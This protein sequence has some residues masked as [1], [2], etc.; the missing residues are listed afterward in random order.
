[1]PARLRYPPLKVA[2]D[3]SKLAIIGDY[4]CSIWDV[5]TGKELSS[6]SGHEDNAWAAAFSADGTQLLSAGG[7][8]IL[9][10]WDLAAG[11]AT[12][13][14]PPRRLANDPAV[15]ELSS[16]RLALVSAAFSASG[17]F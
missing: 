17:K 12:Q 5:K 1:S 7:D 3:R 16:Q 8:G 13:K 4:V 14:Y 10:L 11:K 9:Q 15:N 6:T 2:P